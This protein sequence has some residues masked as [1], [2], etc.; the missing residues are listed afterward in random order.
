MAIPTFPCITL[1]GNLNFGGMRRFERKYHVSKNQSQESENTEIMARLS[2][3]ERTFALGLL[4]AGKTRLEVAKKMGVHKTS[5]MRLE[6]KVETK[7]S[8][9]G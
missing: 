9:R 5:I 7:V 4:A 3:I 1:W 8:S 2:Q 6:N